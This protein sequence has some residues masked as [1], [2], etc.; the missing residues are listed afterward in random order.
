MLKTLCTVILTTFAFNLVWADHYEIKDL[1]T[2]QYSWSKAIDVNDNGQVLG[3]YGKEDK[4][5]SFV[6]D[7]VNGLVTLQIPVGAIP[8]KM[9]NLGQ[10]VG[11]VL[12]DEGW[13]FSSKVYHP[14]LWDPEKGYKDLGSINGYDTYAQ[15]IDDN[16]TILVC[17]FSD[18]YTFAK[19]KRTKIPGIA[20]PI[21]V[22]SY[23][24]GNSYGKYVVGMNNNHQIFCTLQ[25]K[26]FQT[27]AGTI[28][29]KLD[30]L[31]FK[32]PT[33]PSSMNNNGVVVGGILKTN[34]YKQ[35]LV[36]F[37]WDTKTGKFEPLNNFLPV[38]IND[39][40]LMI[41]N[42]LKDGE[43]SVPAILNADNMEYSTLQNYINF[44]EENPWQEIEEVVALNNLAQI[45]GN[46]LLNDARSH[47]FLLTYVEGEEPQEIDFPIEQEDI[48]PVEIIS[49]EEID[50]DYFL[51]R[52]EEIPPVENA[53]EEETVSQG[54]LF[55]VEGDEPHDLETDN[56]V[57]YFPPSS[58]DDPTE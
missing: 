8:V 34:M 15:G 30:I 29:K 24:G 2:F 21:H 22:P 49:Y 35:R 12:V 4:I 28:G 40:N 27:M 45:V 19:G 54:D 53:P 7:P 38:Q 52:Q 58:Q 48:S 16:G 5:C 57:D 20:S 32:Y 42:K 36:G 13:V 33:I 55:E 41:G 47:V 50:A 18:C 14:F 10:V 31:N 25:E 39:K 11:Y 26:I 37:L 56:P 1:G 17:D 44:P 43:L 23:T 9:N 51:T 46:G 3:Q 6:W